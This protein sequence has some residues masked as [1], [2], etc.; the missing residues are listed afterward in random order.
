MGMDVFGRRPSSEAG[1]YFCN[2]FSWWH[3]L[4]E[5]CCEIAP[6]ITK[7]CKLW[8]SNDGD[9]LNAAQSLALADRIEAELATG[10]AHLYARAHHVRDEVRAGYAR[11]PGPCARRSGWSNAWSAAARDTPQRTRSTPSRS[12]TYASSWPSCAAVAALKSGELRAIF[13]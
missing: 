3:P 8:H 5:Y 9:G 6:A 2:N 1:E 11:A 12:R 13:L 4:A 7:H 10:R